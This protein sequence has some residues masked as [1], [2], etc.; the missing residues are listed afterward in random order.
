MQF[1]IQNVNIQNVSETTE[2][3]TCAMIAYIHRKKIMFLHTCIYIHLWDN[4]TLLVFESFNSFFLNIEFQS[5]HSEFSI[6]VQSIRCYCNWY[7][8]NRYWINWY[9]LNCSF[10]V[11]PLDLVFLCDTKSIFFISIWVLEF[12]HGF[13]LRYYESLPKTIVIKYDKDKKSQCIPFST[14]TTV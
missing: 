3:F 7:W 11:Q 12:L 2:L 10:N 6:W 8:I 5:G 9:W 4:G 14:M 13:K 1:S